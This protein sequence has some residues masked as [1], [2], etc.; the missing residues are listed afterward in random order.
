MPTPAAAGGA[1]RGDEQADFLGSLAESSGLCMARLDRGLR[2]VRANG[3]FRRQFSPSAEDLRG[4]SLYDF[5]H[6]RVH[7]RV[8]Y[9]FRYL[10]EGRRTWF[11]ERVVAMRPG[12]AEF[13]GAL[14]GVARRGSTGITVLLKTAAGEGGERD[15][16][17]DDRLSEV[18]ARVLERVAA[19][20]SNPE[21][22][23]RLRLSKQGVEYHIG[24]MLRRFGVSNRAALV[25]RAFTAG[26]FSGAEWPPHVLP[27]Y[28][29]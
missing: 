7:S 25:S 9:Q 2:V 24:T 12:A 13:D 22:A 15:V 23:T 27:Q 14:T 18:S 28:I 16:V 6:P 11:A 20:E 29:R 17:G 3:F 5:L 21:I 1:G 10:A 8:G 19:G 26:L 4:R